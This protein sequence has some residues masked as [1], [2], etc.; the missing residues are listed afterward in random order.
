MSNKLST[1][2]WEEKGRLL[3]QG[4]SQ[5]QPPIQ[6]EKVMDILGYTSKASAEYALVKLQTMG[7]VKWIAGKWYLV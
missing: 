4:M 7:I 3:Q 2:E 1:N 6:I 5:E